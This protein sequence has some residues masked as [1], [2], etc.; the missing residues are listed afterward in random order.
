MG[1]QEEDKW[2]RRGGEIQNS[3]VAKGYSKVSINDFSDIFSPM[4][5]VTSIRLLLS[6]VVDFYFEVEQTDVKTSFLHE[7]LEEEIHMK[8]PEGFVVKG[9]K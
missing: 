3:V 2:K 8:Q 5:K 4:T 9:K 1:V 6:V 7:D